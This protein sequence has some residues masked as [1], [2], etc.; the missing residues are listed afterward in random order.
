MYALIQEP[1]AP[2]LLH[3]VCRVQNDAW[4]GVIIQILDVVKS[5][6]PW[7]PVSHHS[8]GKCRSDMHSDEADGDHYHKHHLLLQPYSPAE[9]HHTQKIKNKT[10]K[11]LIR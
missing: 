5:K 4:G 8:K 3:F 1:I 11:Q 9:I 10:K 6:Q 7:I 2:R